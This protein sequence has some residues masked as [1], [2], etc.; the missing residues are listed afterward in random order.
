MDSAE[1]TELRR[2]LSQQG[3]LLGRQKEE[4]EASR[5]TYSEVLLQLNQLVE[6]L[7]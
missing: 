7:N 2:S 3:M 6:W 5:C 4:L 1:E